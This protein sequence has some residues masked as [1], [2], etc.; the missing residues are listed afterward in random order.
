M[1]N[2]RKSTLMMVATILF[3]MLNGL[4]A[5]KAQRNSDK[6]GMSQKAPTSKIPSA[7]IAANSFT[8]S[9]AEN[10]KLIFDASTPY[11]KLLIIVDANNIAL[12]SII[13]KYNTSSQ[14]N[15]SQKTFDFTNVPAG[16]YYAKGFITGA[17]VFYKVEV[18]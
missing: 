14:T 18:K 3:L 17:P 9:K 15:A 7:F 6:L 8:V 4:Q 13:T 10:P 1:K 5:V 12:H 11:F 16:I 2:I